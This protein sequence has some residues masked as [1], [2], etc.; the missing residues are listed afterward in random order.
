MA[1]IL[2][3]DDSKVMRVALSKALLRIDHEAIGEAKDGLEAI[4]QY[5]A[6]KPDAVL[7]D[8]NMPGIDGIETARRL[9][10]AHPEAK[11]VMVSARGEFDLITQALIAGAQ[12][13][14]AKPAPDEGLKET[15]RLV[16]SGRNDAPK[17]LVADSAVVFRKLVQKA[18]APLN[19]GPVI[20][21][22]DGIETVLAVSKNPNLELL[23]LSEELVGLPAKN[24]LTALLG[25][26][27]LSGK[28]VILFREEGGGIATAL[29]GVEILG[30]PKKSADPA[31]L[32]GQLKSLIQPP[33]SAHPQFPM[34][35]KLA[36][37]YLEGALG[38]TAS[39]ARL[40]RIGNAYF[41]GD[42]W[43]E[44][45]ELL[46][47]LEHWLL[48][49]LHEEG[50]EHAVWRLMLMRLIRNAVSTSLYLP[51]LPE[52]QSGEP[53]PRFADESELTRFI[54]ERKTEGI[55]P[56]M[57]A[58]ECL[59]SLFVP[60]LDF[61]DQA[62]RLISYAP[63]A[64]RWSNYAHLTAMIVK[65][66]RLISHRHLLPLRDN[67]YRLLHAVSPEIDQPALFECEE[68][69]LT[70]TKIQKRLQSIFETDLK[71]LFEQVFITKQPTFFQ[72]RQSGET[73]LAERFEREQF[74]Q[75][76][77]AAGAHAKGLRQLTA[78]L[79]D[80]YTQ[81]FFQTLLD[82]GRRNSKIGAKFLS[83]RSNPD[84]QLFHLLETL[85][86]KQNT[87]ENAV[88]LLERARQISLRHWVLASNHPDLTE[89]FKTVIAKTNPEWKFNRV[90]DGKTLLR[91][92]EA[93]QPSHLLL[94]SSLMV[95]PNQ[96]THA[97]LLK[98]LPY[99]KSAVRVT[100]I[101]P[102]GESLS[103]AHRELFGRD[104][105]L[106]IENTALAR[107]LLLA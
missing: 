39:E 66:H 76:K 45:D 18:V 68:A 41:E 26:G 71:T 5:E 75:F 30:A 97:A 63:L 85:L 40:S 24:A 25:R 81:R 104:I 84:L 21:A 11:I 16:L 44:N 74:E 93:N 88:A 90:S 37:A 95:G 57:E 77:A 17:V 43:L 50:S 42:Q 27:L 2:V 72:V 8:V 22:K 34:A 91:W 53:L 9:C 59:G 101:T 36:V 1:R 102:A 3:V 51:A 78:A 12:S 31:E 56:D 54:A 61:A 49:Y 99:L 20:E 87:D 15:L 62:A 100:L 55:A 38:A 47:T 80:F 58:S 23:I 14:I 92:L 70:L 65:N 69:I 106:P 33:V 4:A 96:R 60:L 13:Y 35:L 103:D 48:E 19:L 52:E 73:Q 94:D 28:R 64:V 6:L 89:Q 107:R 29:K 10:E 67:A 82:L 46:L 86:G 105:Q 7:L 98:S 83:G 79:L 32:S